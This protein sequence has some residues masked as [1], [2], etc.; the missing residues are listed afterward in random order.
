MHAPSR[1]VTRRDPELIL[2][3]CARRHPST[4]CARPPVGS[5]ATCDAVDRELGSTAASGLVAASRRRADGDVDRLR[6]WRAE[7]GQPSGHA[8]RRSR[9]R[10]VS[11]ARRGADADQRR[12]ACSRR[13]LPSRDAPRRG[14]RARRRARAGERR[15]RR[16]GPAREQA[17]VGRERRQLHALERVRRRRRRR[18][19][20]A[21]ARVG[22]AAAA[23][24]ASV[25]VSATSRAGRPERPGSTA[26][27]AAR[28]PRRG[29]PD[30][31]PV[32]VA[33]SSPSSTAP[34][35]QRPGGGTLAGARSRRRRSPRARRAR[36][37]ATMSTTQHAVAA[38]RWA[39]RTP[40]RRT[41]CP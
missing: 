7:R 23:A 22:A 31:E 2:P 8:A 30:V 37:R 21:G 15:V 25:H 14:R 33:S 32:R 39:G 11:E 10:P 4:R 36:P 16:R 41:R 20:R 13:G 38:R 26:G 40:S 29:S 9:R 12:R 5:A 3:A 18:R 34:S 28:R 24:A 19:A 17:P 1:S 6:A 27:A 35:G